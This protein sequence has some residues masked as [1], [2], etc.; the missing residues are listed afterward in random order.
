MSK[1]FTL[2]TTAIFLFFVGVLLIRSGLK[3]EGFKAKMELV[4]YR[5]I[6]NYGKGF[7]IVLGIFCLAL[8]ILLLTI[9]PK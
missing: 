6:R 8:G 1:P 5:P 2:Y 4:H 3:K 9:T 7:S